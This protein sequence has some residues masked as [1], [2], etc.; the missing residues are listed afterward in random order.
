M[1]IEIC[2]FDNFR[3][4]KILKRILTSSKWAILCFLRCHSSL[5]WDSEIMFDLDINFRISLNLSMAEMCEFLL[6]IDS[7]IEEWVISYWIVSI[8]KNL[9][10]FWDSTRS[11]SSLIPMI[12]SPRIPDLMNLIE[13]FN[14]KLSIYWL[15]S[16]RE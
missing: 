6:T 7:K 4:L 14:L 15:M 2:V 16:W 5:I 8:F 9:R 13:I 12:Y 10:L 1:M 11:V 3:L